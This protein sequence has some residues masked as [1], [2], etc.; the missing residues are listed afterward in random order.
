M[1]ALLNV[2]DREHRSKVACMTVF[3]SKCTGV[4]VVR[5]IRE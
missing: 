3:R 2:Y 1:A 5:V 4:H